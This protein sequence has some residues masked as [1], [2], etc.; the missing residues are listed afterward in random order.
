MIL[1]F[2]GSP[3][4]SSFA[5]QRQ[6]LSIKLSTFVSVKN[7]ALS[8]CWLE[9]L[10]LWGST[11]W[12][13]SALSGGIQNLSVLLFLLRMTKGVRSLCW[14]VYFELC[15]QTK[16]I[17]AEGDLHPSYSIH[18][19]CFAHLPSLWTESHSHQGERNA[20][21]FP[22]DLSHLP[23]QFG[24]SSRTQDCLTAAKHQLKW[25]LRG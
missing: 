6:I 5:L 15:G 17:G 14:S 10:L 22:S 24:C 20:S 19:T 18:M 21:S 13:S 7:S 2:G 8:R 3:F 11:L 9:F 1:L 4:P 12:T 23:T 25:Q 16:L